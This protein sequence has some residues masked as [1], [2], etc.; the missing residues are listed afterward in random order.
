MNG[1]TSLVRGS[2]KKE[3]QRPRGKKEKK[4]KKTTIGLNNTMMV[5]VTVM[6]LYQSKKGQAGY[7]D[8]QSPVRYPGAAGL[9]TLLEHHSRTT[10]TGPRTT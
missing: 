9:A 8:R 4:K 5:M 1:I 6:V 7:F 2:E 10:A 3:T